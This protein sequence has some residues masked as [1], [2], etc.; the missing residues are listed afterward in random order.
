MVN[1]PARPQASSG[2]GNNSPTPGLGSDSTSDADRLPELLF[3]SPSSSEALPN[4]TSNCPQGNSPRAASSSPDGKQHYHKARSGGRAA[5]TAERTLPNAAVSLDFPEAASAACGAASPAA[6]TASGSGRIHQHRTVAAGGSLQQ[7]S[8][9]GGAW[10]KPTGGGSVASLA[11]APLQADTVMEG[12]AAH[13][14]TELVA[15][16]ASR[17]NGSTSASLSASM[18]E[19]PEPTLGETGDQTV[20]GKRKRAR[21]SSL[22][23]CQPAASVQQSN[24]GMTDRAAGVFGPQC[25]AV[26]DDSAARDSS[27]NKRT[28]SDHVIDLTH[29]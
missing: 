14:R 9:Q 10:F 13:T 20:M 4:A 29:D 24:A 26:K 16:P 27:S 6:A 23:F 11:H 21:K 1:S 19:A 17:H 5:R 12:E 18:C 28:A 15:P 2:A 22:S 8:E 25:V 3:T 7:P